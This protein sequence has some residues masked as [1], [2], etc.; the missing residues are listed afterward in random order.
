MLRLI[1]HGDVT[2]LEFSTRWSRAIGYRVSAFHARAALIDTGFPRTRREFAAWF[3]GARPVGA[4]VTHAHE[5]HAGNVG[6]L[7]RRGVPVALAS[8]TLAHL[9]APAPIGWYR[10]SCWGAA[11]AL[12]AAITPFE[13]EALRLIPAPGHS[14][15]HHVVWDAE[16]ETL[17]SGDLFISV[18]LRI[19]QPDEDLRG[20]VASL[21]SVLALRPRRVFDAH[22]GALADPVGQLSAKADWIEGIIGEVE[23]RGAAG[24]TARAIR[25]EVLGREDLTGWVS[26]G[27]YARLNVV[28]SI[29]G[30]GHP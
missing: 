30:P 11:P 4:M 6:W 21:R 14:P 29:L 20:Q 26:F 13:P 8:G 24:M 22:R 25:D 16:R 18:K 9:E 3:E 28:R 27:D 5:D 2:E 12:D 7:A 23:R 10:R 15:D 17:Y 1:D 19:A